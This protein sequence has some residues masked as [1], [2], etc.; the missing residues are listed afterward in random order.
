MSLMRID[1]FISER[2]EYTRSEIKNLVSKKLVSA[3]GII[4]KKSDVKINP[5]TV[6]VIVNG[7]EIRNQKFRYIII[8]K[9][10]GY[11]S[12]T[13]DSDGTSVMH[14]LPENLRTKDMF[15]AGRL[16]KDSLGLLL[17]TNDGDL[18]HRILSPT[19]HVSKIYIVKLASPFKSEYINLF[20]N[21]L[22][23]D[24]G[25]QCLPAD[26][27]G[28]ESSEKL[29]FIRL[30]E[31]KFHQVKR[32][33]SA[34]GNHVE[35]LMRISVGSLVLPETLGFGEHMEL[36][37]K[38][39]ESLFSEPDFDRLCSKFSVNFSAKLINNRS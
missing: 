19:R 14:L 22:Q 9:P 3:D 4:I 12:S 29:A 11:V 36:L 20:R 15:P 38:N 8:N 10:A 35:V 1:R 31:G 18:A 30:H 27:K 17:I 23:L 5:D 21:G 16:D 34:V 33:F 24:S 28:A 7:N 13:S 26:V 6:K 2:S 25:E 37:H 39:V 32:M